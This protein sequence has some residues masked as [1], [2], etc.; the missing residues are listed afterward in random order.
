MNR[1]GLLAVIYVTVYG[2][3]IT[4]PYGPT[5]QGNNEKYLL[6]YLHRPVFDTTADDLA[7]AIYVLSAGLADA[8][9]QFPDMLAAFRSSSA[10][11]GHRRAA[12]MWN[13]FA[14]QPIDAFAWSVFK[15]RGH[16]PEAKALQSAWKDLPPQIQEAPA[17]LLFEVK[18][19]IH[20]GKLANTDCN[21]LKSLVEAWFETNR[22]HVMDL[23]MSGAVWESEAGLVFAYLQREWMR[24]DGR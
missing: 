21:A 16:E 20:K 19:K 18:E 7:D 12:A 15:R 22:A 9:A 11:Q 6:L 3:R 10:L 17:D 1:P 23:G 4:L 24:G 2:L 13:A 5:L 14:P 8:A